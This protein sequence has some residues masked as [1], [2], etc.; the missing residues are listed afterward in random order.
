MTI[1]TTSYQY[2][3]TKMNPA[4][5]G[6]KA[7]KYFIDSEAHATDASV[8]ISSLEIIKAPEQRTEI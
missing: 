6:Y 4:E 3:T 1:A 5:G 7:N 2:K 8:N